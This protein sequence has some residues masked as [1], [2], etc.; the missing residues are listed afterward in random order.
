MLE[1]SLPNLDTECSYCPDTGR[2]VVI[3]NSMVEKKTVLY[4]IN[5]IVKEISGE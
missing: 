5:G 3:N 4:N 1:H 2:Y